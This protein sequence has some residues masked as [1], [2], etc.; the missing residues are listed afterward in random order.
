VLYRNRTSL[1]LPPRNYASAGAYFITI[2]TYHRQLSLEDPAIASIVEWAWAS[3]P[4]HF[5][6]IALDAFVVMPNHVHG[7]VV[8]GDNNVGDRHGGHVERGR[9]VGPVLHPTHPPSLSLIVNKFKGAVTRETRIRDLWDGT[10]FW[11]PNFYDHVIRTGELDRIRTYI[12]NNPAAWQY[13]WE[14]PNRID[15]PD[16]MKRWNWLEDPTPRRM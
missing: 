16:H 1:R 6:H 15:D 12:A 3:I 4:E 14:N 10:P 11:Q 8:I 2:C 13:D 9:H 7:I 5:P